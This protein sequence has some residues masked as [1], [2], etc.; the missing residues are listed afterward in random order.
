MKE[1]SRFNIKLFLFHVFFY[2]FFNFLLVLRGIFLL[3]EEMV[4]V[5]VCV[6][7]S[8][9]NVTV[10]SSNKMSFDGESSGSLAN[11]ICSLEY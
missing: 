7:S 2:T 8:S 1:N 4:V 10:V 6:F 5:D 11:E 3:N 9:S